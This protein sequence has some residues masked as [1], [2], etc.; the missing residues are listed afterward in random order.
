MLRAIHETFLRLPFNSLPSCLYEDRISSDQ[1]E[2]DA[3]SVPPSIVIRP[4]VTEPF[5]EGDTVQLVC[6]AT[7]RPYPMI[8]W[9]KDGVL[10]TNETSSLTS[11]YNEEFENNGLLFTSSILEMCSVGADNRGTYSCLALNA[12]GN[13]SAEFDVQV[14]LGMSMCSQLCLPVHF[15]F[16]FIPGEAS[17]VISPADYSV[18]EAS[19]VLA[20][21]VGTGFPQPSISWTFNGSPLENTTRVSIYESTTEAAGMTFVESILEVCSVTL[22]D[23]G[24]FECTVSNALVNATANFTLTVVNVIGEF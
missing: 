11:I 9:Y 22:L 4:N 10:I 23:S 18:D 20:V 5:T 24:L 8:Q 13:D 17:V 1:Y 12:A 14:M 2:F 15:T 3:V 16:I 6:T 21:C 7:G 19:T